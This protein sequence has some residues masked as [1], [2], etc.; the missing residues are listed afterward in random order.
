MKTRSVPLLT[1][2]LLW[3]PFLTAQP[4]DGTQLKQVI[5][6]GR[7]S[8]RSAL[9]PISILNTYSAH[10]FPEFS[11]APGF[12]TPSGARLEAILGSYYRL[13]LTNQGLLTGNDSTDAATAYFRANVIERTIA[14]AQ[15]FAAGLLPAAGVNVN[16]YGPSERDPLFD[17]VGAGVSL[18]DQRLAVA[19]VKGR[20]GDNP[21]SLA[22]AAE[23]A[24]TRSVLFNYP[25]GQTPAPATP[26]GK[27]GCSVHNA[28]FDCPLEAFVPVAGRAID[29]RS[30]DLVH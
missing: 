28:T 7:H 16:H 9:E 30:V 23:L 15:A 27:V 22:Y 18:F 21:E 13:W 24:V 1:L 4:V 3:V 29:P 20:L 26:P 25:L 19:A 12:L 17:P 14:T 11:V 2:A 5:I 6:V 8:V 10:P